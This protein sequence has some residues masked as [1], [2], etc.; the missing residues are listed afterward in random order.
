MDGE[1]PRPGEQ[2]ALVVQ[3]KKETNLESRECDRLI[4]LAMKAQLGYKH[5]LL[6]DLPAG[7]G[8]LSREPRLTWL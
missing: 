8:A 5:G 1:R 7:A 4:V 3:M 6:I 2:A